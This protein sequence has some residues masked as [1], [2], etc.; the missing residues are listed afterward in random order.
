MGIASQIEEGVLL[1]V[2]HFEAWLQTLQNNPDT[3]T[4]EITAHLFAAILKFA[5]TSRI[6]YQRTYISLWHQ[7]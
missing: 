1:V 4:V 2:T 5:I 7:Q 6:H 3:G